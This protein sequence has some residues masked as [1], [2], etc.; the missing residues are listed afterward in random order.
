VRLLHT[1]L[2][3]AAIIGTLTLH[4]LSAMNAQLGAGAH[5][6]VDV[7]KTTEERGA[8]VLLGPRRALELEWSVANHGDGTLEMPS[9]TTALRLRVTAQ[10]R[11]IPVRIVWAADMTLRTTAN[12]ATSSTNMRVGAARVPGDAS[13]SIRAS[14]KRLDGAPFAT[15]DYVLTPRVNELPLT[16]LG[17]RR[18]RPVETG[19]PLKFRILALD[20]LQRQRQFHMVEAAFYIRSDSN[21]ALEH[22]AALASLPGAGWHDSLPLADFYNFLGRHREAAAVFR[23]ILP[24]LIRASQNPGPTEGPRTSLWSAAQSFAIEGD[25][26]TAAKLLRLERRMPEAGIAAQIEQ[27][28]QS[29]SKAGGQPKP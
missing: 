27:W 26:D 17:V 6:R 3:T 16:S 23:R 21:R 8:R 14:A 25:V 10:G 28:R 18:V 12:R 29:A 11:E 24:D 9:P 15:G 2:V 1:S 7:L 20:S 5:V 4:A 22:Y 19:F 13:L